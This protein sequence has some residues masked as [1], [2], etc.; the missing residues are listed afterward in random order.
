MLGGRL[1]RVER[2]RARTTEGEELHLDSWEVFSSQD[3]LDQ[4][5]AELVLAGVATR[6]YAD[7]SEPSATTS[8]TRPG[9]RGAARSPGIGSAPP[10]LPWPS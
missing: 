1:V 6:R 2:H 3:S 8:T 9:A 10:R 4:L 7:V 5:T